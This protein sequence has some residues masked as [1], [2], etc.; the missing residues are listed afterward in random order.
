MLR[1]EPVELLQRGRAIHQTPR[2]QP[3]ERALRRLGRR[4][5]ALDR[6]HHRDLQAQRDHTRFQRLKFFPEQHLEKI[7][8]RGLQVDDRPKC[9]SPQARLGELGQ[10]PLTADR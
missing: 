2:S 7:V 6:D 3:E 5:R 8:G 1:G 10:E 4:R 9:T